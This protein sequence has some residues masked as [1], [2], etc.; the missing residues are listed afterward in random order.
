MGLFNRKNTRISTN[1]DSSGRAASNSG[2]IKSPP[3][4]KASNGISFNSPSMTEVQLPGPPD[5]ALDPAAYLR[6]IYAVR[7]R[8]RFIIV[9]AK[10]NQLSHFDIDA[11]KWKDTVD[12][13]TRIIKRDFAPDYS[14]IPPHGRWQHFEAGGRPRVD[15]LLATWPS[16]VD[17]QERTRRLLDLFLVSVLLDAGAGT[18]WTYRSKESGKIYRRSEGLAV[19]SLEMFKAGC[20]SSDEANPCQ[21]DSAGL[22]KLTVL[23]MERGLQVSEQNPIMGLE[24]RAGLLSRLGDALRNKGLFG[25]AGRPGNMLGALITPVVQQ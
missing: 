19:A 18:K 3:L 1:G 25:T 11:T 13:V 24:G 6:S 23:H 8:A 2:S 5:P 15:Q 10:R 17:N 7:E 20:F 21:V 4:H 14:N 12:Y 16:S 22:R 9:N